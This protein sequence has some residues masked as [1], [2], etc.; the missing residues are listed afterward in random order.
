MK[1]KSPPPL[2]NHAHEGFT[3]GPWVCTA[4][5]ESGHDGERKYL[6]V[7]RVHSG[8]TVATVPVYDIENVA[9]ANARLISAAPELLAVS[10]RLIRALAQSAEMGS[11][12]QGIWRDAIAAVAKAQG[13]K[14]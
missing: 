9:K 7:R 12:L 3:P 11:A 4:P 5:H 13:R 1:K 8:I 14:P 6:Y 2:D 10:E